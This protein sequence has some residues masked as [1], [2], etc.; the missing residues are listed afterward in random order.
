MHPETGKRAC[1]LAFLPATSLSLTAFIRRSTRVPLQVPP[2]PLVRMSAGARSRRLPMYNRVRRGPASGNDLAPMQEQAPGP[3]VTPRAMQISL[4][5][6]TIPISGRLMLLVVPLLWGS[7]SICLKWLYRL[8]WAI[9]AALFNSLR[10]SLATLIFLPQ[11]LRELCASKPAFNRRKLLLSGAELGFYGFIVN[12][13]QISGLRHT[14]AS[15]GA[16]LSQLA[17]VA[18]P[19]VAYLIGMEPSLPASR[20][21]AAFM[22]L[23]GVACLTLDGAGA[24]FLWR[25]DG[26]LLGT[27]AAA[28]MYVLRSKILAGQDGPLVA[29]KVVTQS[30]LALLFLAGQALLSKAR[31]PSL[32]TVFRGATPMLLGVNAGI[33]LWAGVMV[34]VVSG[35]LQMRGQELV[36]ASEAVLMFSFT[37]LWVAVLAI[38]LGERFGVRGMVGAGLIV[39]SSLLASR[40]EGAVK[41]KE[42]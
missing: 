18:V 42:V 20:I 29:A 37:P 35:V 24:P 3:H 6:V 28:T 31:L 41:G 5:G 12:V 33:V 17:T 8:P 2:A 13:L 30:V 26:M 7:Y 38:P 40:P 10:L 34:S 22:A 21:L 11:L 25:G 1:A 19:I 39:A 14:T 32:A 27:A 9:S 4:L 23:S 36:S 16:F 15:R